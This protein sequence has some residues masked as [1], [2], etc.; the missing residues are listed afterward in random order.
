MVEGVDLACP[1]KQF[2]YAN[3]G[4]RTNLKVSKKLIALPYSHHSARH[5]SASH[6]Y[7]RQIRIRIFPWVARSSRASRDSLLP[8]FQLAVEF[9][10]ALTN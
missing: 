3:N 7:A 5:S 8:R 2:R 4:T 1:T 9:V 10:K 6:T